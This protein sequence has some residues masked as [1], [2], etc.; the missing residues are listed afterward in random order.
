MFFHLSNRPKNTY[1]SQNS[2]IAEFLFSRPFGRFWTRIFCIRTGQNSTF[3]REKTPA[4]G[5]GSARRGPCCGDHIVTYLA[6]ALRHLEVLPKAFGCLGWSP[7]R[8]PIAVFRNGVSHTKGLYTQTSRLINEEYCTITSKKVFS[9]QTVRLCSKRV[10][11][12]RRSEIIS[13]A[14]YWLRP[15]NIWSP[16]VKNRVRVRRRILIYQEKKHCISLTRSHMLTSISQL[17]KLDLPIGCAR[18]HAS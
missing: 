5:C 16:L 11:F 18:S 7:A 13:T 4:G 17:Q 12:L 10:A 14:T 3:N 15:W 8:K 6:A 1:N 9:V 2:K